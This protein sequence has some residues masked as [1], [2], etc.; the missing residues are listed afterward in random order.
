MNSLRNVS[1]GQ[2][3]D[4]L[5]ARCG[6]ET[7]AV[8]HLAQVAQVVVQY[9]DRQSIEAWAGRKLTGVEWERVF[10]ELETFSDRLDA[11]DQARDVVTDLLSA[12]LTRAGVNL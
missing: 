12:A 6:G 5:A 2:M 10:E 1:T 7:Q 9:E 8:L 11:H 3:L 4:E